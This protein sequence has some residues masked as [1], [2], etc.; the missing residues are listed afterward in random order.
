MIA[1]RLCLVALAAAILVVARFRARDLRALEEARRARTA[2][3]VVAE[4]PP[5]KPAADATPAV[6]PAGDEPA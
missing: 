2:A 1:A 5:A 6:A 4:A 3:S